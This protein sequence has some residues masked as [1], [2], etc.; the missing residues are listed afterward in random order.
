MDD[1]FEIELSEQI[2]EMPGSVQLPLN[3]QMVGD[4]ENDDV[5]VY[6]RQDV[7][8]ALEKYALADVER[9]RGTIILGDFYEEMGKTHIIVSGYIEARYTEASASTLTFTHETWDYVHRERNEK[10]PSLRI[11]GWQH[12]HPG[13]GI[14]L[15]NYDLFIH[16]NFFNLPFQLAY[17][18]DPV[19]NLRGFFQWKNGKIEKLRGFYIY[20]DVGKTIVMEN[21]RKPEENSERNTEDGRRFSIIVS[22]L[23]VLISIG[24]LIVCAFLR[25]MIAEQKKTIQEQNNLQQQMEQTITEQNEKL[26]SISNSIQD[27]DNG[28]DHAKETVTIPELLE[29]LDEQQ[30]TI[31]NQQLFINELEVTVS[32]LKEQVDQNQSESQAEDFIQYTVKAGDT[33]G[34]ICAGL[35]IDYWQNRSEILELNHISDENIIIIGQVLMFPEHMRIR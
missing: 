5:R 14:F 28:G 7:Y 20:D 12:T 33:L 31:D 21:R 22:A 11:V 35:N 26:Q 25:N 16:E 29:V 10:Y 32:T 23:A 3:F 8:R 17:V 30:I 15:S 13:Y 34:T 1:T 4:I 18:I 27:S 24:S 6:I 9:E 2:E 19:Q